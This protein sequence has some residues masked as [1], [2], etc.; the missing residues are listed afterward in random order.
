MTQ[1][2]G[3]IRIQAPIVIPVEEYR[4]VAAGPVAPAFAGLVQCT[5]RYTGMTRYSFAAGI[6]N[7]A[8]QV[9]HGLEAPFSLNQF[10]QSRASPR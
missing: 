4:V 3:F 1:A 9:Y 6:V 5:Q 8:A 2:Q 7:S 10:A